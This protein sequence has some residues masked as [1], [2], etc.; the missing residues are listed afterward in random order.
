MTKILELTKEN[1]SK[2][3]DKIGELENLTL[4]VMK[5]EGREGQLFATGAEDISEYIHSDENTVIVAVNE[6]DEVEGATY[7][8][9]GQRPFTYNDIT[10][11]FKYGEGYQKYVKSQ[12]ENPQ[13]YQRDL[14]DMYKIKL[15]AFQYAKNLILAEYPEISGFDEFL[16]NEVQENGFH[17]KSKLREKMNRYMSQYITENYGKEIQDKYQQFYW[18]SA[19]DIS[20]EFGK[21]I[22]FQ[23]QDMQEYG[24]D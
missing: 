7:V 19:Q 16:K 1:E 9:Q 20:R 10:K 12:Y 5:K 17:E 2:Y 24:S 18:I 22:N 3:L 4:E 6:E 13:E 15:Q 23:S 14:L 11:Y 21:T 8:T